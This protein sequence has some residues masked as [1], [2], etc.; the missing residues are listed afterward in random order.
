MGKQA[1]KSV[2]ERLEKLKKTIELHRY[3]YHVLDQVTLPEEALD[4]LKKELFDIETEYPELITPDSPSQ[5]V[6]GIPLPEFKKVKHVVSQWSFND[7]FSKD[8]MLDFDKRVKR[9]ISQTGLKGSPTY[10]AELKI[11]GLKIVLSYEKGLLK[12]GAT[13]GDGK[14]GEDVTENIK[15]MESVPLSLKEEVDVIVRVS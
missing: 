11:D 7:A 6:G 14:I 13:R 1:P 9:F 10:C 4:S 12:T 5:R 15:T 3:N 8:D 2:I